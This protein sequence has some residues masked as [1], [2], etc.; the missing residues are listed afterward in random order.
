MA[1]FVQSEKFVAG[2]LWAKNNGVWR[3][4]GE[5]RAALED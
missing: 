1:D 3:V 5:A 2:G 4:K